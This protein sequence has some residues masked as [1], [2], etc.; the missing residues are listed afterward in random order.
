M[1]APTRHCMGN[2]KTVPTKRIRCK[3]WGEHHG[4]ITVHWSNWKRTW[5]GKN[6]PHRIKRNRI[7]QAP[8]GLRII[9]DLKKPHQNLRSIR[10][11]RDKDFQGAKVGYKKTDSLNHH[12]TDCLGPSRPN[13]AWSHQG[14]FRVV[15]KSSMS[16][17]AHSSDQPKTG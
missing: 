11:A 4:T 5:M 7:A 3:T 8:Q 13:R 1:P 17:S 9:H 2:L 12:T 6:L 14:I 15:L 16:T 10:R